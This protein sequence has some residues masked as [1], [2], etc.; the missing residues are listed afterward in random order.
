M[1]KFY[2]YL[3]TIIIAD[4]YIKVKVNTKIIK[5]IFSI[6]KEAFVIGIPFLFWMFDR[7]QRES[8]PLLLAR[9]EYWKH[10][11]IKGFNRSIGKWK[12]YVGDEATYKDATRQ[13]APKYQNYRPQSP[14]V[15][16]ADIQTMH[17]MLLCNPYQTLQKIF[18]VNY[19][20]CIDIQ[21]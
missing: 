21:K 4:C 11:K 3:D 14:K 18:S 2:N 20:N 10:R 5:E 1:C 7:K 13:T 12:R 15:S 9:F 8:K 6:N 16:K 17:F 19:K